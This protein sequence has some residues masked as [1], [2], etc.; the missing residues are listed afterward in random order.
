MRPAEKRNTPTTAGRQDLVSTLLS[1]TGRGELTVKLDAVVP[2][3]LDPRATR[4]FGSK[5]ALLLGLAE[6]ELEHKVQRGGD[7]GEDDG[8]APEAP[9]PIDVREK[10]LGRLGTGEGCD[11][12]RG[13]G[14]GIRETSVLELGRIGGDD[15]DAEGHAAEAEGVKDLRSGVRRSAWLKTLSQLAQGLT[16]AAQKVGRFSHAAISTRPRVAKLAMMRKPSARPQR[17]RILDKGINTAAEMELATTWMTLI[18]EWD[19]KSLVTKGSKLPRMAD[20]RAL[21]R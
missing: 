7:D 1:A 16:Y 8:E 2:D 18:S 19:S 20:C 5:H 9:S 11:H 12:V 15:I 3:A 6:V 17:S 4:L 21:T 10:V 14:E 13:G